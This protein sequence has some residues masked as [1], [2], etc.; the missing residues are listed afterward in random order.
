[1][2]ATLEEP[3]VPTGDRGAPSPRKRA[4][5]A[6]R[7]SQ[8]A[9]QL[10]KPHFGSVWG[11]AKTAFASGTGL[12]FILIGCIGVRH[13]Q[14]ES[15]VLTPV[16]LPASLSQTDIS[17]REL[18][19]RLADE[20]DSINQAA[21]SAEGERAF[22]LESE[23]ALP[24]VEVPG[25]GIQ[26][27]QLLELVSSAFGWSHP[28]AIWEVT[29]RP[30]SALS[31]APRADG[32]R[33]QQWVIT[34]HLSGNRAHS[35]SFDPSN[36]DA[37]LAAI[38]RSIVGDVAP[39]VV[40]RALLFSDDCEG[41]RARANVYLRRL[42]DSLEIAR[43]YNMLGLAAEC[44]LNDEHAGRT[45]AP[46]WGEAERYYLAA[47]ELD[48]LAVLPAINLARM[49]IQRDAGDPLSSVLTGDS[50]ASVLAIFDSAS[51]RAPKLAEVEEAWGYSLMNTGDFEGAIRHLERAR[52]LD[53]TSAGTYRTLTEAYLATA[54]TSEAIEM[55]S[56]GLAR[57]G[58]DVEMLREYG[59][60]LLNRG[61]Y[62]G[63][64]RAFARALRQDTSDVK[65]RFHLAE[66][67]R[68]ESPEAAVRVF[69]SVQRR[70]K[71]GDEY[72]FQT[73]SALALLA[74]GQPCQKEAR[75]R[76]RIPSDQR[77]RAAS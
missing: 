68:G 52:E 54:D 19:Q 12:L 30:R 4:A 31:T 10:L 27:E 58:N 14:S 21:R 75:A 39:L 24:K 76:I 55:F 2:I 16:A 47:L 71:R 25:V 60:V 70:T 57:N 40:V 62:S 49:R 66:S 46:D 50:L 44:P 6:P 51:K 34:A 9:L 7:L 36:P 23:T 77:A 29:A 8:R 67:L 48:P 65:T 37:A 33:D 43:M 45:S 73:D 26:L 63:A 1:M 22:A 3:E 20:I 18:T 64:R 59:H 56:L 5:E 15:I 41:A 17:A 13:L 28:R 61:D 69:C 72:R 35:V 38:A 32:S 74:N 11:W 53:P 42:R